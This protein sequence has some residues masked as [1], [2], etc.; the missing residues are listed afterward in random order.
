MKTIIDFTSLI[1]PF[2]AGLA[3]ALL[4]FQGLWYTVK[5]IPDLHHPFG[6]AFI[7]FALRTGFV[8]TGFYL[9]MGGKPE[10]LVAALLGFVIVREILIRLR[11]TGITTS[12]QG[13]DHGNRGHRPDKS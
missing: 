5:K 1:L 12:A 7:S 11:L 2:I 9:V 6:A 13:A 3:L 10:R 4:Y 8:L